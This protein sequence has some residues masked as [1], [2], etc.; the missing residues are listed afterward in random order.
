MD[1]SQPIFIAAWA[2]AISFVWVLFDRAE[3]VTSPEAKE[4]ASRWLRNLSVDLP[5]RWPS[6]FALL[7]DRIFGERHLSFKCFFRSCIASAIS[8]AILFLIYISIHYREFSSYTDSDKT[9]MLLA[10][11][12]LMAILNFVPDYISLLETR[13]IIKWMSRAHK[14]SRL[15]IFFVFDFII[16]GLIIIVALS[17][18]LLFIFWAES[19]SDHEKV[20]R[21]LGYSFLFRKAGPYTPYTFGIFI[22]STYFTSV[23]IWLYVISGIL[24]RG[25]ASFGSLFKWLKKVL[26]IENQPFR[27]IGFVSMFVVSLGFLVAL[28]FR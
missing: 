24:V 17:I 23:W 19:I 1:F 2:G 18:L 26:D 5:E 10:I 28:F 4:A 25:T 12:S 20:L 16:T 15:A 3:K 9:V 13:I 8:V 21:I 6:Q 27:S 11:G 7:F 14:S 22:Y